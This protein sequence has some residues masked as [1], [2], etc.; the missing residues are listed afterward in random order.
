M[1]TNPI[2][3]NAVIVHSL[4]AESYLRSASESRKLH[5]ESV[6][7]EII[8]DA[9]ARSLPMHYNVTARNKA[10]NFLGII[11]SD[12]VHER[13]RLVEFIIAYLILV[14]YRGQL[15]SKGD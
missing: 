2:K 13:V 7:T 5:I 9:Q 11:I 14:N 1:K 8:A 6:T 3:H 15:L 12:P 10:G 4:R